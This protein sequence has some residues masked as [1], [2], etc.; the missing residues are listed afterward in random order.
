M[1]T[2]IRGPHL[3]FK[4]TTR[5]TIE[6]IQCLA[7]DDD[8]REQFEK[9]PEDALARFNIFLPQGA[10]FADVKLPSK[11]DMKAVLTDVALGEPIKTIGIGG[12]GPLAAVHIVFLA[13]FAFFRKFHLSAGTSVD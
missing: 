2:K 8:Y 11:D 9:S 12:G 10:K 5:E 4:N 13:F 3:V 6:L 7:Y 1:A